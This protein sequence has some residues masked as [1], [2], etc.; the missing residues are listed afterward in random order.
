MSRHPTPNFIHRPLQFGIVADRYL[1]A[2]WLI[3]EVLMMMTL[4]IIVMPM[5]MLMVR[6][7]ERPKI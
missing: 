2:N 4:V 5:V 6:V 3:I 1:P 7:C